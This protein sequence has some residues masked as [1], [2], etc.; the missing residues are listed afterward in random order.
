MT[1]EESSN[2]SANGHTRNMN[3][4]D[5]DSI[6]TQ[7]PSHL[8]HPTESEMSIVKR[9]PLTH[10]VFAHMTCSVPWLCFLEDVMGQSCPYFNIHSLTKTSKR[11]RNIICRCCHC[12]LH[13]M[14]YHWKACSSSLSS[15]GVQFVKILPTNKSLSGGDFFLCIY[16]GTPCTSHPTE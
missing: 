1:D 10:H 5:F 14:W 4:S 2:S 8:H 9:K 7:Q 11:K 12:H 3:P 15:I 13:W 16:I 6:F